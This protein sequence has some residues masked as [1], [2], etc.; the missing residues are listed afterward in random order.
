MCNTVIGVYDALQLEFHQTVIEASNVIKRMLAND[1]KA[2]ALQEE[3]QKQLFASASFANMRF[4]TFDVS[5]TVW[6]NMSY[7]T[8]YT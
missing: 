8:S 2:E 6:C 4:N 1:E 3:H 7:N 5:M